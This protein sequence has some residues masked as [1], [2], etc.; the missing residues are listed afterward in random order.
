MSW[1]VPL[2]VKW[3]IKDGELTGSN[4]AYVY[5]DGVTAL[6]GK[7]SSGRMVQAR[8]AKLKSTTECKDNC[9]PVVVL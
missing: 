5:P 1:V 7:F 6:V 8:P 3:M 9:L 2:W 4:I